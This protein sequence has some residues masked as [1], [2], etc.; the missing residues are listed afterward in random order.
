MPHNRSAVLLIEPFNGRPKFGSPGVNFRLGESRALAR[1][2]L[3]PHSIMLRLNPSRLLFSRDH[4]T[5]T[6]YSR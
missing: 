5:C 1:L 4:S 2:R 6:S 3:A